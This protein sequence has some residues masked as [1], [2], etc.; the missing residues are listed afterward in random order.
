MRKLHVYITPMEMKFDYLICSSSL[1]ILNRDTKAYIKFYNVFTRHTCHV[2]AS[3][4]HTTSIR[5]EERLLNSI[6]ISN[7]ESKHYSQ[8]YIIIIIIIIYYNSPEFKRY[9][10]M[11]IQDSELFE[12]KHLNYYYG[13]H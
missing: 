11:C 5:N 2:Y 8:E 4:I 6:Q 9:F 1:S 7:F 10:K 12:T 3:Y 13:V